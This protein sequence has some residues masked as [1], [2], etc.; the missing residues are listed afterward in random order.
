MVSVPDGTYTLEYNSLVDGDFGRLYIPF[1]TEVILYNR[2]GR[3]KSGYFAP[4]R[5]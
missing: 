2:S 1:Q 4:A 3:E 5:Y